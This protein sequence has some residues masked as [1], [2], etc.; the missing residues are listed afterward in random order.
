MCGTFKKCLIQHQWLLIC[1]NIGQLLSMGLIKSKSSLVRLEDWSDDSTQDGSSLE[2][3]RC[4]RRRRLPPTPSPW[5]SGELVESSPENQAELM[6]ALRNKCSDAVGQRPAGQRRSMLRKLVGRL[7]QKV[8]PAQIDATQ[9]PTHTERHGR[10]DHHAGAASVASAGFVNTATQPVYD[11]NCHGRPACHQHH[12]PRTATTL[13]IYRSSLQSCAETALVS[14]LTNNC[15][16]LVE[17]V[18]HKPNQVRSFTIR[19]L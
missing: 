16:M 3:R 1:R 11:N 18:D 2:Y 9:P 13:S 4:P 15:R 5:T 12:D 17:R 7:S 8:N 19:L 14:D 10:H 6:S